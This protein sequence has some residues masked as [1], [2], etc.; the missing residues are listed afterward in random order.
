MVAVTSHWSARRRMK[1]EI[2]NPRCEDSLTAHPAPQR[3]AVQGAGADPG[4]KLA[5][6][7]HRRRA[8]N[9]TLATAADVQSRTFPSG[10]RRLRPP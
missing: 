6:H 8:I 2:G 9:C 5:F 3:A 4:G 7:C 1:I 10:R